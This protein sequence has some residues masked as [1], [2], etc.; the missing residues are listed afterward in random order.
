[1]RRTRP[2]TQ[3]THRS[4]R[5]IG[6]CGREARES[7]R[8]STQ[9]Q[10]GVGCLFPRTRSPGGPGARELSG[11]FSNASWPGL[12]GEPTCRP[13][14]GHVHVRRTEPRQARR[15]E[16]RR[17]PDSGGWP[18][19]RLKL[20][21]TGGEGRRAAYSRAGGRRVPHNAG[22]HHE[23]QAQKRGETMNPPESGSKERAA[24]GDWR[25]RT[26]SKAPAGLSW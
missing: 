11:G 4:P 10:V 8:S 14:S 25:R 2:P 16:R 22:D 15:G 12:V 7:V 6:G 21:W 1:M 5:I 19:R 26:S 13:Q 18:W 3:P 20:R 9:T 17:N 23:L 24:G